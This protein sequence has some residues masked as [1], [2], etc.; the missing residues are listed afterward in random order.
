MC[1]TEDE[2]ENEIAK[3]QARGASE[4]V[5]R[6]PKIKLKRQAT[7]GG[8]LEQ[9]HFAAASMYRIDVIHRRRLYVIHAHVFYKRAAF[10][11]QI[12]GSPLES[13]PEIFLQ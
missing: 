4:R 12:L 6:P 10:N 9:L 3:S 7:S 2:E 11:R 13:I 5:K 1:D 8:E